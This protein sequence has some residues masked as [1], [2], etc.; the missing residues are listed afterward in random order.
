LL[1]SDRRQEA[2]IESRHARNICDDQ[3]GLLETAEAR[4]IWMPLARTRW[5]KQKVMPLYSRPFDQGLVPRPA[6]RALDPP[7]SDIII[8][9]NLALQCS[10]PFPASLPLLLVAISVPNFCTLAMASVAVQNPTRAL[11]SIKH[12]QTST[13][14]GSSTAAP[15]QT[16][17]TCFNTV[18][19]TIDRLTQRSTPHARVPGTLQLSSF[20]SHPFDD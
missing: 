2:E 1:D 11:P 12:T 20:S 4:H 18:N 13:K 7:S 8:P 19:G 16:T 17:S 14:H 6:T 3:G 5:R 15:C 9:A 10:L